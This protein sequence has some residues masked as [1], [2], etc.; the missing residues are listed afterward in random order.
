MVWSMPDFPSRL[1][2]DSL[3]WVGLAAGFYWPLNTGGATAS[4]TQKEGDATGFF[5]F[6][7]GMGIVSG[8]GRNEIT[9]GGFTGTDGGGAELQGWR[10][11]Q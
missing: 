1:D 8:D 3:G 5:L 2:C 9:T 4:P 6:F 11:G 10:N 7:F